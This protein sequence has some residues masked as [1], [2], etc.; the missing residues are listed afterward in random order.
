MSD[1]CLRL[2]PV[3][4]I[5][6]PDSGAADKARK[7]LTAFVPDASQVTIDVRDEVSFI[8]QGANFESVSCSSC[9]SPIDLEWW[10]ASLE[11]A[12]EGRCRDLAVTPPCCGKQASLNDLRYVKPAGFARFSLEAMNPNRS[13][14]LEPKQLQQLESLLGCR[15]RQIWAHY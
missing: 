11:K 6:V 2:I 13:E 12:T 15:L 5:F 10:Q 14:N 9:G 1:S 3:D 8:D 7:L 4:P